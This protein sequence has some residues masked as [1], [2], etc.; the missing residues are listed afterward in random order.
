MERDEYTEEDIC[1]PWEYGCLDETFGAGESESE[2]DEDSKKPFPIPDQLKR[3]GGVM[4]RSLISE[5]DSGQQSP[6]NM[7]NEY[8]SR[9]REAFRVERL[10]DS[11]IDYIV[12]TTKKFLEYSSRNLNQFPENHGINHQ[13]NSSICF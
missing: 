9:M 4:L 5:D 10:E 13:V 6:F 1:C 12:S 8:S 11:T 7:F 2:W 3:H